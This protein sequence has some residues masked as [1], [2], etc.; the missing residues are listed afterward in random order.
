MDSDST[1]STLAFTPEAMGLSVMLVPEHMAPELRRYIA[2]QGRV[3]SVG[4]CINALAEIC[5]SFACHAC[6]NAYSLAV[7]RACG[8]ALDFGLVASQPRQASQI[9]RGMALCAVR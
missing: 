4:G 1:R 3:Y 7:G 2:T 9:A 8:R 6:A 5:W